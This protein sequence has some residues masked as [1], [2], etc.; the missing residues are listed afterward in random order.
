MLR[1]GQNHRATIERDGQHE[2]R[3]QVVQ[4]GIPANWTGPLFV[5]K[6]LAALVAFHLI[7]VHGHCRCAVRRLSDARWPMPIQ[8]LPGLPGRRQCVDHQPAAADLVP[9]QQENPRCHPR[10]DSG[11]T[12]RPGRLKIPF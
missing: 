9:D 6:D 5:V 2:Q 1:Q 10:E 3:D 12:I 4:P 7:C 8:V 11:N